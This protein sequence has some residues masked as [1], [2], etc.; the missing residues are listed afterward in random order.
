MLHVYLHTVWCHH[1]LPWLHSI[2][3]DIRSEF[4][5][6]MDVDC[7]VGLVTDVSPRLRVLKVSKK[8]SKTNKYNYL[9][10]SVIVKLTNTANFLK[11]NKCKMSCEIAYASDCWKAD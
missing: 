1:M 3:S 5:K 11:L 2:C 7:L 10:D 6:A 8:E 9:I 4:G